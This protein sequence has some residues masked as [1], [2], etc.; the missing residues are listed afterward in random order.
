MAKILVAGGA[1]YIGSTVANVLRDFGHEIWV[2]DDLTTGHRSFV[3]ERVRLREA[4][5]ADTHV[6][7]EILTERRFDAIVDAIGPNP[8]T[9]NLVASALRHGIRKWISLLTPASTAAAG[10]DYD[11]YEAVQSGLRVIALWA[12][13]VGG[14][15]AA[16]RS[17]PLFREEPTAPTEKAVHVADVAAAARLALRRLDRFDDEK[18]VDEGVFVAVN[19]G[20]RTGNAGTR[21]LGYAPSES[22]ESIVASAREWELR[23]RKPKRAVFLD[24]DGTLNF[25]PMYL[26][27][28]DRL[29]LLPGVIPAMRAIRDAGYLM[30]VVSNQ[31]G[32]GRGRITR[33]QLRRI[34][35]RMDCMLEPEGVRIEEYALCY[36]HPE[37]GCECRKPRPK[38]ILDLARD[39]GLDLDASIMIGDKITDIEVG[40]N[41]G[42]G[43][44]VFLLSGLDSKAERE[45]AAALTPLVYEDLLAFT[46]DGLI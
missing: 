11:Y 18:S 3:P 27:D 41:A 19:L 17:G 37:D 8:H 13:E 23:R 42:C 28:P 32:I 33:D 46:R 1:G 39:Y 29:E 40:R 26:N 5:I 34:H 14:V 44:S 45:K 38:L 22:P 31:S 7:D 36:H 20:T 43:E 21:E 16:Y 2:I 4:S 25:D 6:L 24:R 15:E 9:G 12:P 30:Y 10:A 35:E